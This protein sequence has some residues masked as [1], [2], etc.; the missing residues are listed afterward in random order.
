MEEYS[1]TEAAL[2][3]TSTIAAKLAVIPGPL[4]VIRG[5]GVAILGILTIVLNIANIYIIRRTPKLR[6]DVSGIF[7]INLAV[8]DLGVGMVILWVVFPAIMEVWPFGL[9]VCRTL[10]FLKIVFVIASA[11]SLM[12]L[13][14]DRCLA[15]KIPLHHKL[16]LT[17]KRC[18]FFITF[19]WIAS[20][21]MSF[22]PIAGIDSYEF[23]QSELIC[24]V[25]SKNSP[26]FMFVV[27][28]FFAPPFITIYVMNIIIWREAHQFVKRASRIK[29]APVKSQLRAA[30]TVTVVVL[31]FTISWLPCMAANIYQ[32]AAQR[33]VNKYFRQ[34]ANYFGFGNSCMNF[35]IY[36]YMNV[37]FRETAKRFLCCRKKVV[38]YHYKNNGSTAHRDTARYNN[39]SV[40]MTE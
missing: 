20:V 15:I 13:S 17:H 32:A 10:A 19:T 33:D 39:I 21:A 40:I 16:L 4:H 26:T 6:D 38:Q 23:V 2:F 29:M 31:G 36:S 14:V 1:S 37:Y 8:A 5:I 28:G 22:L 25:D 11:W 27:A 7:M 12:L 24:T 34:T 35:F 18:C 3:N 9:I 30:R